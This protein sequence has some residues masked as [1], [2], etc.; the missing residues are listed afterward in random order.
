MNGR[1]LTPLLAACLLG[2]CLTPNVGGPTAPKGAAGAGVLELPNSRQ[3]WIFPNDLAYTGTGS[4]RWPHGR[5]YSGTFADGRPAGVGREELPSGETYDGQWREGKRHGQGTVQL[6]DGAGYKGAWV[7]GSPHGYG[8]F[9][10]NDGS[11]YAG[12]W[13]VGRREGEG[14][15]TRPNDSRYEGDWRNDMPHGR[16]RQGATAFGHEHPLRIR[17][18]GQHRPKR[19]G[20]LTGHR[21]RAWRAALEPANVQGLGAGIQ[22]QIGA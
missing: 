19:S 4:Y 20:L 14:T 7:M 18:V 9:N 17:E 10:Y 8:E 13:N 2:G 16:W 1:A 12:E 6:T 22:V 21:V 11:Y 3:V 5:V 15:Y